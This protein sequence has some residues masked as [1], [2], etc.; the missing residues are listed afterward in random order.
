MKLKKEGW[1]NN[2]KNNMVNC[3]N[4]GEI[5]EVSN[6]IINGEDLL[7]IECPCC[8]CDIEI[9]VEYDQDDNIVGVHGY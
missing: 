5:I 3:N 1:K 8:S 4:C 9:E 6:D 2:M 7:T